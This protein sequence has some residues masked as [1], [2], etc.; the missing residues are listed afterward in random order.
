MLAQLHEEIESAPEHEK[1][2]LCLFQALIFKGLGESKLVRRSLGA[3]SNLAKNP[4]SKIVYKAWLQLEKKGEDLIN[5]S[6][7]L[8]R[9]MG[10]AHCDDGMGAPSS[11][12]S[13]VSSDSAEMDTLSVESL[14]EIITFSIGS[15]EVICGRQRIASLSVPF[16]TMLNGCFTESKLK[17]IDFSQSGVS[18]EAMRAVDEFS[19]TGTLPQLDPN[20]LLEVLTFA[21]RFCCEHIKEAC[22]NALSKLALTG[23]DALILMEYGLEESASLLVASCLE[24]LLHGLPGILQNSQ[25]VSLLSRNDMKMFMMRT[26]SAF[27]FYSLLS[28]VAMEDDASSDPC[29]MFLEC[30]QE[31]AKPG[32]ERAWALHLLGC[33]MLERKLFVDAHQMF[34]AAVEEG[35]HYSSAGLARAKY[36]FGHRNAALSTLNLKFCDQKQIGWMFVERSLYCEEEEKLA[37]LNKATELDPTLT[38]PYKYRAAR[39]MDESKV[40]EAILEINR[41]LGFKVTT[42]CLE[43]RVYFCLA[44]QDYAGAIRDVRALLTLNPKYTLYSGRVRASKLLDLLSPHVE[45]WNIAD[46]WMQLYDRWSSVDDIGSLAVVHQMLESDPSKALLFFRQSLLL[47]RLNCPKSAMQSL[48]LARENAPSEPERLVYEGWI[49]YDTGHCQEAIL[50]AQKSIDLQRSFEAFFL[51]AYALA[52]TNRHIEV[53]KEVVDLLKEALKCPSDGLRKGQALNNLGSVYVDCGELDL[54]ADAYLSALEIRH[55]RAHQGLARVY[56]LRNERASAYEEMTKLIE[57]AKNNASAYEK[58]SEYCERS[59]SLA[60]LNMVTQLDPLRTYP[61]RYRAAVLM[62]GHKEGEAIEELSKAIAFKADLHLLHLRAA[63]NEC[64]GDTASALRD[65]HAALSVDPSHTETMQLHGRVCSRE[66]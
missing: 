6:S 44:A 43:L 53:S 7:I 46:C 64:I 31:S 28:Q 38:Y 49:L 1:A 32:R 29:V 58:R 63:F 14:D 65:C 27:A 8:D 56:Y 45:Q 60:D 11:E 62:D 12:M 17:R 48:Q 59:K 35:H 51:K 2:N 50:K 22:D 23:Q 54:A 34:E 39:L 47:L 57:K 33:S 42:D 55:T 66:P 52:D 25:V 13:R 36:E 18:M 4:I 21:N 24:V 20:G 41:I 10:T 37:E 3:A 9:H 15:E 40:D 5:R 16:D 19:R 30:L 61:Y 26:H